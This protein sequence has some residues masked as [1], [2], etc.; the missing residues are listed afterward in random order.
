MDTQGNPVFLWRM[1]W[2]NNGNAD[3]NLVEV[4]DTLPSGTSYVAGSLVCD[5]QGGS[6]T[7]FCGYEAGQS[8]V[9]WRGTIAGDPG[10][11]NEADAQNEVVISF[12]TRLAAG[13]SYTENL[14]QAYWDENGDTNLAG[15]ELVASVPTNGG[16]PVRGGI[17][18]VPIPVASPVLLVLLGLVLLGLGAIRLRCLT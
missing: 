4:V 10:A 5:P 12:Q 2:I 15:N 18:V 1:V 9:R 17:A 14:A 16:A 6:S 13:V 8:R 11:T 7:Q 3:A